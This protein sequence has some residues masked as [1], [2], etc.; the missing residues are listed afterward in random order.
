LKQKHKHTKTELGS[1]IFT[2]LLVDEA[3]GEEAV[4]SS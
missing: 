2:K 1:T 3:D 4:I